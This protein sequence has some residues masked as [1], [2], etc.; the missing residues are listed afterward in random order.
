MSLPS[1]RSTL[2]R[3]RGRRAAAWLALLLAAAAP[4][5][6]AAEPQAL[7]DLL[8]R[9]G[10]AVVTIEAVVRTE[11]KMGGQGEDQDSNLDLV[12]A[13]V[14]PS[15]LV[16]LWNSRISSARVSDMMSI[17]GGAGGAPGDFGIEMTPLSFAVRLHGG[18]ETYDAFLA[19]SDPQLDLAFL[20]LAEMPD[21]PLAWIDLAAG[22]EA[23]LTVGQE[24]FAVNRLGTSFAH[25]PFVETG[26]LVGELLKPRRA[27]IAGGQLQ[28]IGLPLFDSAGRAVGVLST[29]LSSVAP[30]RAAAAMQGLGNMF[31]GGDGKTVGPLGIFVLPAAD[32]ARSVARSRERARALLEERREGGAEEDPGEE[33]GATE[34]AAGEAEPPGEPEG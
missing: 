5:A 19:A 16:M 27:W 24:V 9:H 31:G 33:T 7:R 14:D 1:R 17:M 8:A 15:G 21:E 12:G 22:G 32:A 29:V 3:G 26:V 20:Q 2:A 28:S 13:V 4:P 23:A 30:E 6:A 10:P 25:A 34:A 11:L 18:E